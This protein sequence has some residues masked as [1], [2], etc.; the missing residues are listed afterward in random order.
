MQPYRTV[1]VVRLSWPVEAE[2]LA[3]V[4]A[5]EPAA[6]ERDPAF[7]KLLTILRD[8]N[9]L[10]DFGLYRAVAEV[11]PCWELFQPLPGAAPTQGT[12][13]TAHVSSNLMVTIHVDARV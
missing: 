8:E 11:S 1:R 2:V 3:A 10:G 9:C 5:G 7:A 13:G 4:L 6:F 12:A